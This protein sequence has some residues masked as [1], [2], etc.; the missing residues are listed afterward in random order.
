MKILIATGIYP[1]KIGGPAQYAKN[2]KE[3]FEKMGHK[4]SIRT[5]GIEDF[6]PTGIRH[7]FFFF[8][9][10]P[11]IINSDIIFTLDTFSVGL[12]SALACKVLNK[13]CIIRTGG[14]FLWEQY[15]E[16]TKKK[17]LLRKFYK[18]EQSNFSF[19]EQIIFK[20]T[21]WTLQNVNHT[22]FSTDWQR[23]IFID[24]Y[25][26]DKNKASIVENFYGGKEAD[27]EPISKEFIGSTRKLIWKN[28]DML[29]TVFEEVKKV[30]SETSLFLNNL[31]FIDLIARLKNSY[32]VI[33]VSLGDISPNMILDAIRFNR[34]FI[35]TKEV[36]IYDRIKDAGIFV[37]PLNKKE[38]EEAVS[39]LLTQEGYKE[40]KERVKSF[41]FVHTWDQ[42]AKEFLSIYFNL[43]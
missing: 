10:I 7:L 28:L 11:S 18:T 41:N 31:S 34:P 14:D 25:Q 39:C 40:A 36:G 43:K 2:L 13:K 6:L 24:A 22:I 3:S 30:T 15:V 12:P 27:L 4:V 8:K 17:V 33:L 35:C 16:R 29:E 32:A 9:I 37:D 21:K 38:I 26:T 23:Q 1:P 19:K 42:I 5:Y 20:L